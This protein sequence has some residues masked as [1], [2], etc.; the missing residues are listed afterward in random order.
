MTRVFLRDFIT[1]DK[2]KWYGIVLI[3]LGALLYFSPLPQLSVVSTAGV[4]GIMVCFFPT[5][6]TIYTYSLTN[7]IRLYLTLPVKSRSLIFSFA[8]S[9]FIVALIERI[10]FVAVVIIFLFKS[11]VPII[12]FLM[13]SGAATVLINVLILLG[14]NTKQPGVCFIG[15]I[16]LVGL[17]FVCAMVSGRVIQL[18]LVLLICCF[19]VLMLRRYD[20][21]DLAISHQ[22]KKGKSL[23]RNYFFRV[24]LTEKIYVTNT[25]IVVL[26]A[27]VFLFLFVEQG[28]PVMM[29]VAW[30]VTAVNT[31]ATTMI[32]GDKWLSR[33]SDMLPGRYK[34]LWE[35][36]RRFLAIYFSVVNIIVLVACLIRS[37]QFVPYLLIQFAAVVSLEVYITVYLEK[38]RRISGWQ[39]KQQLWR[40]PRKYI[41]PVIVFIV[42]CG[43]SM[44]AEMI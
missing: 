7:N 12:I 8:L 1:K 2:I 42:A 17:T 30:C 25:L 38:H 41:L 31:P 19:A 40:N 35:M 13:F 43:I 11:P 32:S 15:V 28:N 10:A 39:T 36:Y 4:I 22:S 29:S 26:F 21:L 24:L 23:F 9:L 27:I 3:L 44:I 34:N 5:M 20:S 33:Q 16:L 18:T 37:E 6:Y 14:A